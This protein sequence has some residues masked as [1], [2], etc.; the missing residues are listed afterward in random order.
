M[1]MIVRNGVKKRKYMQGTDLNA[2][3][4]NYGKMIWLS[5]LRIED[6]LE[7]NLNK[8]VTER[9]DEI[10]T[11]DFLNEFRYLKKPLRKRGIGFTP[12]WI[13]FQRRM[14]FRDS[15]SYIMCTS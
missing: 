1:K 15:W 5:T 11:I 14:K 6:E 12:N 4:K 13:M 8:Y 9:Y 10:W 2:Y 7:P 3:Y